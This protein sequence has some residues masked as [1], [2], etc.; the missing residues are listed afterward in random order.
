M[1]VRRCY[2]ANKIVAGGGAIELELSR[3]MKHHARTVTGKA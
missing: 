3:Y 1:I 2:K